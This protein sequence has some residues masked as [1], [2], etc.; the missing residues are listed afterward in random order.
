MTLAVHESDRGY[1]GGVQG[2]GP[3]GDL[4]FKGPVRA[5]L[6]TAQADANLLGDSLL[7]F[8]KEAKVPDAPNS[9]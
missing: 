5:D 4:E 9:R 1:Q 6:R 8:V 2:D 7:Q 3:L